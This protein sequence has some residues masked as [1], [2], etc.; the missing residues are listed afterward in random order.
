MRPIQNSLNR[1]QNEIIKKIVSD[2]I[3]TKFM[4]YNDVYS[5][6]LNKPSLDMEQVDDILDNNIFEF[7]KLQ[8][9]G[10]NTKKTYLSM[11]YGE[12]GYNQKRNMSFKA[13][14]FHFYI[15]SNTSI[16]KTIHGNRLL[17]IEARLVDLFHEGY[18]TTLGRS[19]VIASKPLSLP[20]GYAGREL[21]VRF[22]DGKEQFF[23]DKYV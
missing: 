13:M 10:E 14:F 19:Q 8:D 17:E 15:V 20:N 7:K 18:T 22:F 9:Y 4:Y 21:V 1:A 11:E 5:N 16:V 6:I 23:G 12:I 2:D 3:L